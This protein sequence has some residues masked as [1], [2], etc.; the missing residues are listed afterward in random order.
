MKNFKLYYTSDVHG[1][2]FPTDYI[3][4]NQQPL[5]LINVAANYHKDEQTIIVDGGDMYQG[6]PLLQYLQK[7]SDSFDAVSTAMNMA[8]Y[9]YVTLGNHDFNFGYRELQ[10]H[11]SQ[12]D[13]TVIAE[14]VTDNA[15]HTLYPA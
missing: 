1:Y 5:G 3:Q 14:N 10:K 7:H 2:L 12:L 13:A 8:G 6:S 4:T 9:D 15:G 11:L